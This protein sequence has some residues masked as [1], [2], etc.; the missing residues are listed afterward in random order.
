MRFYPGGPQQYY[1]PQQQLNQVDYFQPRQDYARN[2]L[3]QAFLK[4]QPRPY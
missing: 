3:P 4:Q 2:D 1:P